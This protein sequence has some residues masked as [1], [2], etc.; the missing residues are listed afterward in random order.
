MNLG[1]P[2]NSAKL[3]SPTTSGGFSQAAPACLTSCRTLTFCPWRV[4]CVPLS[5]PLQNTPNTQPPPT[6]ED[7]RA[8]AAR[9]LGELVRKMGERVL[10]R[11]LPILRETMGSPDAATRQGVCTGLMEV[12]GA[13]CVCV[14]VCVGERPVGDRDVCGCAVAWVVCVCRGAGGGH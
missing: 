5:P 4:G 11:M 1:A 7:R 9:C 13:C 6:G 3:H 14:C 12:R 8:G 2:D 10:H